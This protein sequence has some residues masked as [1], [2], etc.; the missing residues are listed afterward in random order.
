[1]YLK[2]H[3]LECRVVVVRV[4][5]RGRVR[6]E[7]RRVQELHVGLDCGLV[8]VMGLGLITCGEGE[9]GSS[10]H[11]LLSGVVQV[12]HELLVGVKEEKEKEQERQEEKEVKGEGQREET[13]H[14]NMD[15]EMGR[16]A[17]T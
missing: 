14:V 17:R 10:A 11:T 12:C 13:A 1:M 4:L 15:V 7:R 2:E 16:M 9:D 8:Q 6:E 5:S 3:I